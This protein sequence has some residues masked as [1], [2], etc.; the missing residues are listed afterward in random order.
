MKKNFFRGDKRNKNT[1]DM[2][3]LLCTNLNTLKKLK[4]EI[5]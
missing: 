2:T 3:Y 1:T 5:I 4:Y